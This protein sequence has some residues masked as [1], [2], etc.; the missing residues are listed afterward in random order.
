MMTFQTPSNTSLD[1]SPL[2]LDGKP[3]T[4]SIRCP[5]PSP[6]HATIV[7]NTLSVDEELRPQFV[8]REITAD[9]SCLIVRF[10]AVDL[11]TLRAA[12]AT[13]CDLLNLSCR[14]LEVFPPLDD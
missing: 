3:Y 12:S 10:A 7:A 11:R 13:F 6:N 14:T 8:T 2:I 5:L 1:V 4:F 9:G